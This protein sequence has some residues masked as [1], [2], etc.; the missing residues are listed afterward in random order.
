MRISNFKYNSKFLSAL[1]SD[2]TCFIALHFYFIKDI[3]WS[4][5]VGFFVV[6]FS[7]NSLPLLA[8]SFF[9]IF[10]F[11]FDGDG[12]FILEAFLKCLIICSY[13]R[14]RHLECWLKALLYSRPWQLVK[15]TL[16]QSRGDTALSSRYH[17]NISVSEFPR[18]GI[19]LSPPW[20]RSLA[21]GT[22][23][24]DAGRALEASC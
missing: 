18:R 10:L 15:L 16:G 11:L 21:A 8:L 17:Q 7:F 3:H 24:L 1:C 22:L 4:W 9:L 14:T 23:R 19:L 6:F 12:L 20:G 13:L 5:F 2:Y